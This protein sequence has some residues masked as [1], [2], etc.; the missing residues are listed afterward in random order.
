MA[1][2][3]SIA[4]K[5]IDALPR[6]RANA[7]TA[8]QRLQ[9]HDASKPSGE[10]AEVSYLWG[11]DRTEMILKI[12]AADEAVKF[13]ERKAAAAE[14]EIAERAAAAEVRSIEKAAISD[15]KLIREADA[16]SIK[17]AAKLAEI[18]ASRQRTSEYNARRGDRPHVLDAEERLRQVPGELYPGQFSDDTVW[19]DKG[20]NV[21][22]Q[23]VYD[24]AY[25]KWINNPAAVKQTVV[26]NQ[27][28]GEVQ[29]P[30]TMP[31]RLADAIKLVD[32]QGKTLWPTP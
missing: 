14:K 19:V 13:H 2:F 22:K 9:A 16:L 25:G 18:E 30:P 5:T 32:L 26:R 29:L 28:V 10:D 6:A 8:R 27:L 3:D 1:L 23:H 7:E 15:E 4:T 31:T 11:R 12:E 21:V 20:G 17:L 24:T